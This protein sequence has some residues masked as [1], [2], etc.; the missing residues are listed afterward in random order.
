MDVTTENFK[1]EIKRID[2]EIEVITR[3]DKLNSKLHS[4]NWLFLH[5][6]N[7]GFEI[8]YFEN[9]IKK[10]DKKYFIQTISLPTTIFCSKFYNIK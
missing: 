9:I 1:N 10:N 2:Q 5:P 3:I 7:Q 8:E 6:F 4:Y